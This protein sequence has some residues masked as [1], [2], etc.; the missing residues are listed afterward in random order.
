MAKLSAGLLLYRRGDHGLEVLIGHMGGPFWSRK[1]AGGWSVP[2]GEHDPD[3]DARAAARREFEEELGAPPPPGDPA[4]LGEVK[5]SGGKLVTVFTLEGDFDETTA[6]SNTFEI[7]YPKGSGVMRSF[8]EL[9]RVAWVPVDEARTKL[10]K[11]QAPFLDRLLL[12]LE[13]PQQV[14]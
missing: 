12:H 4:S 9:D 7:E 6:V 1:D 5:L 11:S 14:E 10:T 2:K 3:E 13:A 8:P